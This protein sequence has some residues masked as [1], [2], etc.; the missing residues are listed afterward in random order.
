VISVK[1]ELP[2][3]ILKKNL[4]ISFKE[5]NT[6]FHQTIVYN[7]NLFFYPNLFSEHGHREYGIP[8]CQLNN[9]HCDFYFY[10]FQDKELS[11][12]DLWDIS[13]KIFDLDNQFKTL[14]QLN[15]YIKN[16]ANKRDASP[17][18]FN[19]IDLKI[20]NN[21]IYGIFDHSKLKDLIKKGFDISII[22]SW[23]NSP[24]Q[25]NYTEFEDR[26]LLSHSLINE[27]KGSYQL[28][29][30]ITD[31]TYLSFMILVNNNSSTYESKIEIINE[32]DL[33]YKCESKK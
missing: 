26:I 21:N 5:G 8:E 17:F 30:K 9:K 27:N 14:F 32:K 23:R 10:I 19:D 28:P 13:L 16:D 24:Q 18:V 31:P 2:T 33:F 12:Q 11:Q 6:G 25:I 22:F 15:K 3:L 20:E 1:L 7:K 29:K 4:V